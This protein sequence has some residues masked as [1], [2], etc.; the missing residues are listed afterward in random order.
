MSENDNKELGMGWYIPAVTVQFADGST[1]VKP[2][3]AVQRVQMPVASR[4]FGLS[5]RTL[6]RL[7]EAGYLRCARPSPSVKFFYPAEIE[8][9]LKL[10]EE[11][12]GFWDSQRR[13]EY[14]LRRTG[15]YERRKR[16]A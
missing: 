11:N 15:E 12:P 4:M 9:F 2:G 5:G 6:S 3:K 16:R 14:G 13:V 7:A 1:L 8:A 10:T